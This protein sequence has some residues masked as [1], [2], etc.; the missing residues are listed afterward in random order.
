MFCDFER[1]VISVCWWV[2]VLVVSVMLVL[3]VN[4]NFK[5]FGLSIL[6]VLV[7]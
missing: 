4:V 3:M 5:L 7:E 6:D 2:R 1:L